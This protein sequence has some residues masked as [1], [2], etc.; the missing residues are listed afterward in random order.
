MQGCLQSVA[1]LSFDVSAL[2]IEIWNHVGANGQ[3]ERAIGTEDD[4][5]EGVAEDPFQ[6]GADDL[7]HAA[8][9]EITPSIVSTE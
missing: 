7:E 9:E 5:D 1:R 4:V 3:P 8:E 6:D 2:G